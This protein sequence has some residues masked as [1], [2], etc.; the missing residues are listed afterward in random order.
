MVFPA[1]LVPKSPKTPGL[2]NANEIPSTAFFPTNVLETFSKISPVFIFYPLSFFIAL[3]ISLSMIF[4][5]I[6]KKFSI[7]ILFLSVKL[8]NEFFC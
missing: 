6:I 1:P 8:E 5:N 3:I 2:S 7:K 4:A